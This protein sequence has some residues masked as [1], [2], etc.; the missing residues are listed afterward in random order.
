MSKEVEDQIS[1]TVT[2]G[3]L[4]YYFG[5]ISSVIIVSRSKLKSSYARLADIC[6]DD[7]GSAMKNIYG[8][9]SAAHL[10]ELT[11]QKMFE[12]VASLNDLYILSSDAVFSALALKTGRKVVLLGIRTS[13]GPP[14]FGHPTAYLQNQPHIPSQ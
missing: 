13:A 11:D 1:E 9:I 12:L 2:R 6:H 4:E 8:E 14:Q 7:L 10:R 3:V 5:M